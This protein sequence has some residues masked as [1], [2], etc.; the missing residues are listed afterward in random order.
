MGMWPETS[1]GRSQKL[2][3]EEA[4]CRLV[5]EKEA[6]WSTRCRLGK[7]PEAVWK[8]RSGLGKKYSTSWGEGQRQACEK[9]KGM[10]WKGPQLD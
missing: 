7:D 9:A 6:G 5:L 4:R 2:V 3:E 10:V 1:W 8:A